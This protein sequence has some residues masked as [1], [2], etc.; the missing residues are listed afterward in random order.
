MSK[1]FSYFLRQTGLLRQTSGVAA[2]EFAIGAV[3]LI[4]L[5]VGAYE[6]SNYVGVHSKLKNAVST[7]VITMANENA[8]ATG[9]QSMKDNFQTVIDKTP[10][11]LGEYKVV[12]ANYRT[13][14]KY[15]SADPAND[16][17]LDSGTLDDGG[18]IQGTCN[19]GSSTGSILGTIHM[20]TCVNYRAITGEVFGGYSASLGQTCSNSCTLVTSSNITPTIPT[21]PPTGGGG[22][23]GGGAC[24]ITAVEPNGVGLWFEALG[25]VSPDSSPYN[26]YIP[27]IYVPAGDSY[28]NCPAGILDGS[29]SPMDDHNQ[30]G[31]VMLELAN[32]CNQ[33]SN[34]ASGAYSQDRT[35]QALPSATWIMQ[36]PVCDRWETV[37]DDEGN[38]YTYCAEG[39]CQLTPAGAS[40][41]C[42]DVRRN[43]TAYGDCCEAGVDASGPCTYFAGSV[44]S[45]SVG[46]CAIEPLM[47]DLQNAFNN[48]SSSNPIFR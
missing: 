40:V 43:P 13:R 33:S 1:F 5:S 3:L 31:P 36:G 35:G 48:L 11:F 37:C 15:T 25:E 27:G 24:R 28:W 22:G 32:N 30:I 38:C 45:G 44:G 34:A 17:Q 10:E 23:G 47:S 26:K 14:L 2:I 41:G 12:N 46:W 29:I 39:H 18:V 7:M 20:Q 19:A 8:T 9:L 16:F 21:P 6:V 42:G 4:F